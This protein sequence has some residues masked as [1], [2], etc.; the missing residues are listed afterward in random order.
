VEITSAGPGKPETL[1]DVT[2][3]HGNVIAVKDLIEA[4]EKDRK[5]IADITEARTALEMVVAVFESQ[6]RG[7]PVKI[8]LENRKDPLSM[9]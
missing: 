6:R 8:P 5:P 9:L 1:K 3:H 4:V 7:T 2:P